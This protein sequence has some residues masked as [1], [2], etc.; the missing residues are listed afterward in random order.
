[1][2][3]IVTRKDL[4]EVLKKWQQGKIDPKQVH[5][6]ATAR[7]S[8]SSWQQPDEVTNEV[9]SKLDMLDINLVISEDAAVF[10]KALS[11][12]LSTENSLALLEKHEQG[13]NV[14]E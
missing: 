4:I 7:Y 2:N 6:W 1:M 12:S 9:L 5:D 10:E 11:Q 13:I 14:F 3:R 8:V